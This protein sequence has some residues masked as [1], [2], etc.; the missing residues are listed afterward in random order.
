M[1]PYPRPYQIM[2]TSQLPHCAVSAPHSS[3]KA[4]PTSV[5]DMMPTAPSA[6]MIYARWS[7]G[8]KLANW[9]VGPRKTGNFIQYN[10]VAGVVVQNLIRPGGALSGV[11]FCKGCKGL[12]RPGVP[13]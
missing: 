5:R 4:V 13:N 12:K 1:T 10:D 7:Q 2:V 9:L 8:S 3:A 6:I 11:L